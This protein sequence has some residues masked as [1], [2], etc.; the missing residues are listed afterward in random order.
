[1]KK[2]TVKIY[3]QTFLDN[4]KTK[5]G[6][7]KN[8]IKS[9]KERRKKISKNC[10]KLFVKENFSKSLSS[11]YVNKISETFNSLFTEEK[12]NFKKI[13]DEIYKEKTRKIL[14]SF[15]TI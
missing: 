14:F 6:P 7:Y 12:K 1:M 9:D 10:K 8:F 5:L 13:I 3:S 4:L 2:K 15:I 11:N